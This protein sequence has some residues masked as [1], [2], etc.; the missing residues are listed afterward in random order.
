MFNVNFMRKWPCLSQTRLFSLSGLIQSTNQ[1]QFHDR[2]SHQCDYSCG[3]PYGIRS[4][5]NGM[6]EVL[7]DVMYLAEVLQN[8]LEEAEV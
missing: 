2:Q 6:K 7:V 1:R 4:G 3:G 5:H 8:L